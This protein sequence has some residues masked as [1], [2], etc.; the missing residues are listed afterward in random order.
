MK[1]NFIRV[2][3]IKL[4]KIQLRLRITENT[5]WTPIPLRE[6]EIG[7]VEL[8]IVFFFFWIINFTS[9]GK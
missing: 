9:K 4:F 3:N 2:I 1:R 6:F 7:Y 8:K 5:L